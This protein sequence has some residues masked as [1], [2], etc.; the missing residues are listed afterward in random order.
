[1]KLPGVELSDAKA[2]MPL[3]DSHVTERGEQSGKEN[4]EARNSRQYV[5]IALGARDAEED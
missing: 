4:R 5:I 1:M 3:S 2:A